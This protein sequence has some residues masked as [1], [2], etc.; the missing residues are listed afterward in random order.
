MKF[1]TTTIA[2]LLAVT[3]SAAQPTPNFVL[4]LSDDQNWDGLSVKMDPAIGTS[5]CRYTQ[6]PVLAKLA[7]QGMRFTQAYA[8]ASVCSPTRASLQTGMTPARLHWT[9]AGPNITAKDNC[10]LIPPQ[11]ESSQ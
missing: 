3:A 5:A 2:G 7:S 11:S 8:P 1:L 10:R 4:L 9:K 6:T